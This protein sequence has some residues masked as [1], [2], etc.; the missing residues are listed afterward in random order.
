MQGEQLVAKVLSKCDTYRKS[1]LWLPPPEVRP[2]AWINN[3]TGPDR[4]VAAILLDHFVY[5][6]DLATNALLR[7]TYRAI[8][9]EIRLATPA[10]PLFG[11]GDLE[12]TAVFT[13]VEDEKPNPTD[14]G[15]I[16]CRKA[17]FVLGIPQELILEPKDA[18]A[19][20]VSGKNVVFLD[21]FVGS[22]NQMRETWR[23]KYA[24]K[25]PTSFAELARSRRFHAVYLNLVATRY[26]VNSLQFDCPELIIR[27]AHVLGDEYCVRNL[28]NLPANRSFPALAD[29]IHVLLA[30]CAPGLQ[31]KAH[32]R[33]A[34]FAL[35]GWHSLG[36]LLAFEHGV[37]DATIPL[38]WAEGP[39]GWTP[40]ARRPTA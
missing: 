40:L 33:Q 32:M 5:Y 21:D 22:G 13:R 36:L 14:S 9:D 6:S 34:D 18:L 8:V 15:N 39:S 11:A 16:F 10:S 23:R 30:R 38:I 28:A 26:G 29:R 20:A 31:L 1:R 25:Q 12:D 24:A 37:P 2:S 17:R 19:A 27:S 35:Y 3:F 7:S 4:E